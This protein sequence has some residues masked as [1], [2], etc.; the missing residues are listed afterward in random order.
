MSI[1]I[2]LTPSQ[3]ILVSF[4]AYLRVKVKVNDLENVIFESA[5]P[6]SSKMVIE[7]FS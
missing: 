4:L 3:A 2:P 7:P 1:S 5:T 6:K